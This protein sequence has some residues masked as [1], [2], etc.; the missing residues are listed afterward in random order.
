M[1]P[2]WAIVSSCLSCCSVVQSCPTLWP[3]QLQHTRSLWKYCYILEFAQVH[4]NC[5][6]ILWCPLLL[7]PLI[8]LRSWIFQWV[9]CLQQMTK[10][11]ELQ[12]QSFLSLLLLFSHSVMSNS[13]WPHRLNHARLP[14]TSPSLRA[15]SKWCHPTIWSSV[16]SFS[17]AFNLSQNQG[18]FQSFSSLQ[19]WQKYWSFS[20]SFRIFSIEFPLWLT[21]LISM[22]SK[23]LSRVLSNTK[24]QKHQSFGAQPSLCSNSD[25]HTW[26]L[27]KP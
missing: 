16:V 11:L 23:G 5:H 21:D 26:L 27:E 2:E 15:C 12:L 10:M 9:V 3:Y 1:S 19:K 17:L 22:Q 14:C 4:I 25:I 7:L 13:L 8:S 24:V 20:F 18:L 6:L